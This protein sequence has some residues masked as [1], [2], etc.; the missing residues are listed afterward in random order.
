M[1]SLDEK[2]MQRT[3]SH[4]VLISV[5]YGLALA[6]RTWFFVVSLFAIASVVLIE[7]NHT[8]TIG[9]VVPVCR[10]SHS[11]LLVLIYTIAMTE[12]RGVFTPHHFHRVLPDLFKKI[13]NTL[14]TEI[15]I[16]GPKIIGE[17][18]AYI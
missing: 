9:Y 17:G 1:K 13:K 3:Q 15:V 10:V 2:Q 11:C 5:T 8:R 18:Y 16:G 12:R 4:M 14:F 6:T 7:I